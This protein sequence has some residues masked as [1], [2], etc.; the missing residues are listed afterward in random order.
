MIRRISNIEDRLQNDLGFKRL[1]A[2]WAKM[3]LFL[4]LG[5]AA[6]GCWLLGGSYAPSWLSPLVGGGLFVA[7]L[8]LAL[9]GHRSHLYQSN[10]RIAAYVL[11]RLGEWHGL[12]E[13]EVADE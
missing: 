12:T 6:V 11:A 1:H 3:E 7:G 2:G 10:T 4:G 9:A 8:Y 5:A 13:N